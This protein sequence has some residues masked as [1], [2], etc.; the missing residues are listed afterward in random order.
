MNDHR[1]TV[2]TEP[3]VKLDPIRARENRRLKRRKRV[4]RRKRRRATMTN[5]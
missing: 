4:L 5:D 1:H 2:T 3:H